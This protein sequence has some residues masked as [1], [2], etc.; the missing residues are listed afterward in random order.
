M[1]DFAKRP[2]VTIETMGKVHNPSGAGVRAISSQVQNKTQKI[3]EKEN[4]VVD[5]AASETHETKVKDVGT[6]RRNIT[7]KKSTENEGAYDSRKKKQGGHGKG[8]WLE[9]QDG[10]LDDYADPIDVNDPLYDETEEAK[11][12]LSGGDAFIGEE[13]PSGYHESEGKAIYGPM[14]TLPE[15]KIRLAESI[16]EYFDSGDSDEVIRSIEELKCRS[17]HPEVV[18]KAISLSLDEGPR[19]RELISRL[20]TCLHP[21]PLSEEDMEEGFELLLQGLEELS[22]DCPDAKTMVGSFLARA[23]VD[24]VL[25]PKYLSTQNNERPG[26]PVVEKA[27]SLLSREH[28][29]ARLE[30]VWGPG[31]GRPV[32]ELKTVLDQLLKE[33]LMSRE[34][35]EAARCVREMNASHFHHELVKRGVTHAMEAA[36]PRDALDAMSAL[37]SFL[38][39]NAIV[40]EYQVAKGLNRLNKLLP[41]LSLD[42]PTAPEL[43]AEFEDMV[44]ERGCLPSP[45]GAE[46][47]VEQ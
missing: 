41:D 19:E 21:T 42:I 4:P 43:L 28:C 31:D 8:K 16:R 15:F 20:L 13:E 14:L 27:V 30:H 38:T 40:S 45:Q 2:E 5:P 37:F 7:R 6:A 44:K 18:K 46:K 47:A 26:D 35:D 12:I 1:A 33:Y 29:T 23:V 24:E 10:S 36:D 11:Y 17:F 34:L 3:R 9:V 39:K 22:I 25:P 32:A